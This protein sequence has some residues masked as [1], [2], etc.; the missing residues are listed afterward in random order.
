MMWHCLYN[1]H[2]VFIIVLCCRIHCLFQGQN[3]KMVSP[4]QMAE[5]VRHRIKVV[6]GD[7]DGCRFVDISIQQIGWLGSLAWLQDSI[8]WISWI[9]FSAKATSCH[10]KLPG[11]KPVVRHRAGRQRRHQADTKNTEALWTCLA[12]SRCGK[13]RKRYQSLT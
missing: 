9:S 13:I 10:S 11:A 6:R 8:S 4:L 12:I 3:S 5:K 2:M 1:C 7:I